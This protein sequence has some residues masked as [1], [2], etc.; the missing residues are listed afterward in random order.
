MQTVALLRK[1]LDVI[2]NESSLTIHSLKQEVALMKTSCCL[3]KKALALFL[4]GSML[5][6]PVVGCGKNNSAKPENTN[7]E[8]ADISIPDTNVSDANI[9]SDSANQL[10]EKDEQLS[11]FEDGWNL[12]REYMSSKNSLKSDPD[13]KDEYN[14]ILEVESE[15]E[16]KVNTQDNWMIIDSLDD[17]TDETLDVSARYYVVPEKNEILQAQSVINEYADYYQSSSNPDSFTEYFARKGY[18]ADISELLPSKDGLPRIIDDDDIKDASKFIK[19]GKLLLG[20]PKTTKEVLKKLKERF[21]GKKENED[22]SNEELLAISELVESGDFKAEDF[23]VPSTK[24]VTPKYVLKQALTHVDKETMIRFALEVG[25]KIVNIIQEGIKEKKI[26]PDAL[27][28]LKNNVLFQH[29]LKGAITAVLK[30]AI[31]SGL[32]GDKF[33]NLSDEQIAELC[34]VMSKVVLNLFR[35]FTSDIGKAEFVKLVLCEIIPLVANNIGLTADDGTIQLISSAYS[36]GNYVASLLFELKNGA[37]TQQKDVK[38]DVIDAD[39][40]EVIIPS[41]MSTGEKEIVDYFSSINTEVIK[42]DDTGTVITDIGNSYV[43]F[44]MAA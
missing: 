14:A 44:S 28:D 15:L 22:V 16:S 13:S 6:S 11:A 2:N 8:V 21:Q 36:A 7:D 17:D 25:P 26:D 24:V 1:S 41:E 32:L 19:G 23:G 35:F 4:C 3:W 42:S 31:Q 9:P 18:S 43:Q 20:V 27:N 10:T 39:G 33:K 5:C 38:L 40:I 34:V 12:A 30:E 37:T 29:L